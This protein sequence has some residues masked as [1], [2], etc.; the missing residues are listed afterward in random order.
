MPE[1]NGNGV[2]P[3]YV[4]PS[5]VLNISIIFKSKEVKAIRAV[6]VL[7]MVTWLYLDTC[8]IYSMQ[9]IVGNHMYM[10]AYHIYTHIMTKVEKYN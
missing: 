6:A 8:P 7:S 1:S 4:S 9:G 3:S 5:Y 10:L 2:N